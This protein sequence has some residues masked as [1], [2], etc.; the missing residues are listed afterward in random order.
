[1]NITVLKCVGKIAGKVA[2]TIG[3]LG[4]SGLGIKIANEISNDVYKDC[5]QITVQNGRKIKNEFRKDDE[6]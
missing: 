5:K 3:I 1:M 2:A 6:D 4:L